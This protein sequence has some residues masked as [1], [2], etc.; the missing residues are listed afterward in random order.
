MKALLKIQIKGKFPASGQ[1]V[2]QETQ[3]TLTN[4]EAQ[5]RCTL[6]ALLAPWLGQD[7]GWELFDFVGTGYR[8]E[9]KNHKH[10]IKAFEIDDINDG[11][12]YIKTYG[13]WVR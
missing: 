4:N 1:Y 2:E 6:Q 8:E 7:A 9:F 12:I 5:D 13:K 11:N 3:M 10:A